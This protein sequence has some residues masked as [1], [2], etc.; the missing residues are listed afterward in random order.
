M[1]I[2]ISIILLIVIITNA[3]LCWFTFSIARCLAIMVE[4]EPEEEEEAS[5]TDPFTK[6]KEIY[7][8]TQ[9]IVVPKTPTEIRN[10]NFDKIKKGI[11]YGD[12][13]SG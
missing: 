3:M 9:H 12:F 8:S 5:V 4:L 11:E 2:L 6:P 7:S 13:N 10:Q 1:D